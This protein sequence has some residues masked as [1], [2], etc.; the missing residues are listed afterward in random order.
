VIAAPASIPAALALKAATATAPIV[1]LVP[2]AAR[3][4]VMVNPGN[5]ATAETTLRE[6]EKAAGAFALEICVFNVNNSLEIE[7]AFAT[8]PASVPM[9]SSS[10]VQFATLAVA[11]RIPASYA[12]LEY[13]QVGELMS[14]ET[15]IADSFRQAGGLRGQD[16]QWRKAGRAAGDP[17]DQIRVCHQ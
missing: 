14:Y 7:A 9:R 17:A 13:V 11:N 2:G 12:T 6:L 8:M 3:I 10:R 5:V 4:A 16:P 1:F 15:N